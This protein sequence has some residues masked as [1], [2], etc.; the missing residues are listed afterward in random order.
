[1]CRKEECHDAL[2]VAPQEYVFERDALQE[3]NS[4]NNA[5]VAKC[6]R[7][8]PVPVIGSS[9]VAQCQRRTGLI[10]SIVLLEPKSHCRHRL[11]CIQVLQL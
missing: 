11:V 1:M 2:G 4:N 9:S 10:L 5:A 6:I 3:E 8:Q 7:T